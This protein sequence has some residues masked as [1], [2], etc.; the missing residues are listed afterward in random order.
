MLEMLGVI[1]VIIAVLTPLEI[2]F[3]LICGELLSKNRRIIRST[4][5]LLFWSVFAVLCFP[6]CLL[7]LCIRRWGW[8]RGILGTVGGA[9]LWLLLFV[10]G[11]LLALPG[12]VYETEDVA[13]YRVITG[14]FNNSRPQD[15]IDS[16]FPAEISADFV[17]PIWHYKAL[18][19]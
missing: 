19:R 11:L 4:G 5:T 18:T 6:L 14:N 3:W 1:L 10:G 12:T 13:D 8:L 17:D 15:F 9:V 16:F 2:T 7:V